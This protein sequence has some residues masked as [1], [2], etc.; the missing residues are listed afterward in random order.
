MGTCCFCWKASC[1]GWR[2]VL[3]AS[4]CVVLSLTKPSTRH[5]GVE[6]GAGDRGRRGEAAAR[7]L[8]S[9]A[10]LPGIFSPSAPPDLG[11]FACLDVLALPLRCVGGISFLRWHRGPGSAVP[12]T[13]GLRGAGGLTALVRGNRQE[14]PAAL[15]QL[16]G[17]G[18][19]IYTTLLQFPSGPA[20]ACPTARG[21]D[22]SG[23]VCAWHWVCLLREVPVG[24]GVKPAAFF[25]RFCAACLVLASLPQKFVACASSAYQ[26]VTF[27]A[28]ARTKSGG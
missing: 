14:M 26:G 23:S 18:H 3:V 25:S 6:Q 24:P 5:V 19:S 11:G 16:S 2:L 21:C 17:S 12:P 4:F 28:A 13:A 15:A 20:A 7:V 9:S 8:G 1:P 10:L 22:N 27:P